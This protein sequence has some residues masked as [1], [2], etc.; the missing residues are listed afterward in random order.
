MRHARR[1][2]A[3]LPLLVS[4]SLPASGAE[5]PCA[6]EE[7]PAKRATPDAIRE[8]AKAIQELRDLLKS[9]DASI[10]LSALEAMLESCTPSLREVG[11]DVAFGSQDN[12]MRSL[13]L[14]SKVLSMSQIVVELMP[15][16][17]LSSEQDGFV[18]SYNLKHPIAIGEKD[19]A[20]GNFS[21]Q[22]NI[23]GTVNGLELQVREYQAVVR[24]RLGEG[25]VLV[26]TVSQGA[27]SVPARVALR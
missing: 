27:I 12:A 11:Y 19:P 3:V 13:A 6:R 16:E 25:A 4:L 20:S 9:P 15:P 8:R 17:K 7:Q 10:R 23:V 18:R 2:S 5:D 24:L 1:W 22:G 14:K 21:P 26:G